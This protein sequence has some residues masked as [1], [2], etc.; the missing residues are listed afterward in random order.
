MVILES[1]SRIKFNPQI[2]GNTAL[3]IFE[4]QARHL[5]FSN[6]FSKF[7]SK[8]HISFK[9]M[10][11][12]FWKRHER[13]STPFPLSYIYNSNNPESHVNQSQTVAYFKISVNNHK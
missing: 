13:S 6:F 8:H 10:K 9:I 2:Y 4:F 7:T 3:E 1:N 5:A 11:I 12:Q